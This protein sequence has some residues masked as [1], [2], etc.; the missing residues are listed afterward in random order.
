MSRSHENRSDRGGGR[1]RRNRPRALGARRAT[2]ERRAA[3]ASA[4]P[5]LALLLGFIAATVLLVV[6]ASQESQPVVSVDAPLDAQSP[7]TPQATPRR[8]TTAK[9]VRMTPRVPSRGTGRFALARTSGSSTGPMPLRYSVAVEGGLEVDP[10]RFAKA[11][12]ATL[13]DARGWRSVGDHEFE[14]V[15]TGA[16]IRVLLATP[17]TVDRLCAPLQTRGEVSCRNQDRVVINAKRWFFGAT[18][19]PRPLG[20]YRQYVINHE[21]GHA[22]GYPHQPCTSSGAPAPVMLQQTLG[23]DGCA[24]NPWPRTGPPR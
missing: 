22:L 13:A 19:Y 3:R 10:A 21:V 11:V 2:G 8:V 15:V 1:H 4:L 5:R 12:E 16:E 7:R 6:G 20:E 9:H 23:L 18:P 17:D 24:P 14:R